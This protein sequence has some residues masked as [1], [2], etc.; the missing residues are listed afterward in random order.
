MS[1]DSKAIQSKGKL[2]AFNPTGE[3]YFSKGLKAYHRRDFNKAKKYLERAI[4]LEPNEPMIACQLAVLYT[5]IGE[6]TQSNQLLHLIID[7]L[8][9]DMVECHYFLANNYAHLGFFKDAYIHANKYLELD[10]DG[11]FADDTE[12]LL[13]VL[14][15][16]ADE[17][18]EDLYEQDDL[19][20]KQEEARELLESGNFL[21][22]VEILTHVIEEYP[23][24]W[25]AYNNLALAYFYLG[26]IQKAKNLLDEV[27]EK[28]QGNLHA[29]CNKLVFSFYEK[30]FD[31]VSAQK[32]ALVKIKPLLVDH[33]LKLGATFALIG[34][35][36]SSFL[37]LNKLRKSGFQ[38]DGAYYYWLSYAA[39]NTKRESLAKSAWEKVIEINPEK[40]G[41]EPWNNEIELGNGFE[42]HFTSILKKLTSEHMEERLFALFLTSISNKKEVIL[43]SDG[44]V[45]N[46]KLSSIENQ[47][48]AFVK[49][50]CELDD[51]FV[52]NAHQ[53][54]A[55]LY[56]QHHPIG[57]IE[58]GLYLMWFSVCVEM[59]KIGEKVQ[60]QHAWAAATEYVWRMLRNEKM[61]QQKIASQ[62]GLSSSTLRKYVKLVKNYL[63]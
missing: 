26:E 58:A 53:T 36:E 63:Q 37:W 45:H 23:T 4:Q 61:S 31:E 15:L 7:Q 18:E 60:N 28:N 21:K 2:L 41:F 59:L 22:A 16:E 17:L 50:E 54:A 32:E 57:T 11:D 24:Y 5:E 19:I 13:D 38:G 40:N 12:D 34:E 46:S 62:Y 51:S 43:S 35:Y 29:L 1:K 10:Q 49:S 42:N 47:Y 9:K 8:D 20:M 52:S 25:S 39:Y 30:E 14:T 33:Q 27:L 3:Y 44:I 55:L 6:Y 48:I 56:Q